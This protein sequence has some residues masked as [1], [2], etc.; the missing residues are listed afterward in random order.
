MTKEE[1]FDIWA[2]PSGIWSPWAKPVLF[3]SISPAANLIEIN[4]VGDP[5]MTWASTA[6]GTTAIVVDLPGSAAVAAGLK[7]ASLGYRPVPLFNA[8]SDSAPWTAATVPSLFPSSAVNVHP[9]VSALVQRAP[10]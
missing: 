5:D 3:S 4:D 6:D 10:D 7:L 2:P 1:I 9:I 8:I